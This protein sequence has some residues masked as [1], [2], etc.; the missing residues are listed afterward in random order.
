MHT[1]VDLRN[2]HL[3]RHGLVHRLPLPVIEPVQEGLR[4]DA[5]LCQHGVVHVHCHGRH[6]AAHVAVRAHLA[7]L[8]GAIDNLVQNARQR[9]CRLGA[10]VAVAARRLR[11]PLQ[12]CGEHARVSDNFRL[13]YRARRVTTLLH[14]HAK[15]DG[16]DA[17]AWEC[18][19][20]ELYVSVALAR[21]CEGDCLQSMHDRDVC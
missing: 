7:P 12:R 2:L 13:R 1:T 18:I 3:K 5:V 16:K 11:R 17:G 9:L 21:R 19:V 4:V 15:V 20:Q 6:V 14:A 8:A 10:Q